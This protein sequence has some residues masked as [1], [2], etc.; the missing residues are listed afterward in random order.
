VKLKK[1]AQE[2]SREIGLPLGTIINAY[3]RDFVREKRVV[4]SSPPTPNKKTGELLRKIDADIKNGK[5][6]SGAFKTY[7]EATEYL[8]SL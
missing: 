5:N 7:D 2:V 6:S 1:E 4:F 8:D 3:L